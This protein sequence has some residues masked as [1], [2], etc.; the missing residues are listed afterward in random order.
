MG[1]WRSGQRRPAGDHVR[2]DPRPA[3]HGRRRP[4]TR[5]PPPRC[6]AARGP[7]DPRQQR[8]G[9]VRVPGRHLPAV[10]ARARL[11]RGRHQRPTG[12]AGGVRARPPQRVRA[13]DPAARAAA[14]PRSA[15]S[16][17]GAAGP[18][19]TAAIPTAAPIWAATAP[20]SC[21]APSPRTWTAFDA[22]VTT[23]ARGAGA[24]P[25]AA[26]REDGGPLAL[27]ARR[28][29]RV[30]TPI[31]PSW[32]RPTTSATTTTTSAVCA[33]R[34]AP[35]CAGPTRATPSTPG[36]DRTPRRRSPIDT[37][38]CVAAGS[39]PTTASRVCSSSP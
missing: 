18:A 19:R 9:A 5:G 39:S 21:C 12:R 17:A 14:A 34:S 28:W 26:R 30:R 8:G 3:R 29:C 1:A 24:G 25:R 36:P 20:T 7:R 10:R 38:C 16:A 31:A 22:Y 13:A 23:T 37:G 11:Q 6:G 32:P 27:A 4:S 35:T 33:A 2:G 15:G